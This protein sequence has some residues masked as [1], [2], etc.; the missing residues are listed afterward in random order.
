MVLS[1]YYLSIKINHIGIW[2]KDLEVIK[3]FYEKYFNAKAGKIYIN[4]KKRFKSYFLNFND[5]CKIEIMTKESISVFSYT[6]L[7]LSL[8]SKDA[9]DTLT[10]QLRKDGYTISSEPRTTGDGFYKS[11]VEVPEGNLIELTT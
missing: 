3:L 5:S 7:A 6:H 9:V 11:V 2:V 4:P 1:G 10:E 8:S